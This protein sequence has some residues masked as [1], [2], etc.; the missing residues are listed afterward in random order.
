MM[1]TRTTILKLKD[2]EEDDNDS[3]NKTS[4]AMWNCDCINASCRVGLHKCKS[5]LHVELIWNASYNIK[6]HFTMTHHYVM[7]SPLK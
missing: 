2:Q 1:K 5:M 7:S 3:L 6:S 4:K